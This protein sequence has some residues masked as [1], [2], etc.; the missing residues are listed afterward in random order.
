MPRLPQQATAAV[1][2]TLL[3]V[4]LP[5]GI[6]LGASP[7]ARH[8]VEVSALARTNI[9][10]VGGHG[11]IVSTLAKTKPAPL[12]ET[13]PVT[14][15]PAAAPAAH[16]ENHGGDVSAVAKDQS[17]AGGTHDNHG[18]AVAPVAHKP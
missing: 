5:A 12:Q 10:G 16:P 15:A 6:A 1:L 7:N 11:A 18:G 14:T 8:G 3:A 4:A 9:A 17:A 13:P 2:G